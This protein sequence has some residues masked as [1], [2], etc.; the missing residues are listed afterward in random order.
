MRT[1]TFVCFAMLITFISTLSFSQSADSN[2][3]K[4]KGKSCYEIVKSQTDNSDFVL[5]IGGGFTGLFN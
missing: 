2:S 3:P 4:T 1:K 5:S